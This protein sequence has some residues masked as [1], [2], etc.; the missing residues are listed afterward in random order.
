MLDLL[1]IPHGFDKLQMGSEQV[2]V[3]LLHINLCGKF[4][5]YNMAKYISETFQLLELLLMDYL[6]YLVWAAI[7]LYLAKMTLLYLDIEGVHK[8][9]DV[10]SRPDGI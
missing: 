2:Y 10:T 3:A 4:K 8:Y 1:R 5:Y 7:R 6:P 9:Y